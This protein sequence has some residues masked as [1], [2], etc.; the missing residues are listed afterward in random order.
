MS[1]DAKRLER[2]ELHAVAAHNNYHAG[3]VT[4]L[5]QVLGK[6]PPPSGGLTW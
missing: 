1:A 6:W 4:F 5:R 3:Q 2:L